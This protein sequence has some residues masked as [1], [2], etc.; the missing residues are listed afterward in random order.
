MF[1]R[2]PSP[3]HADTGACNRNRLLIAVR[4]SNITIHLRL[5]DMGKWAVLSVGK[6]RRVCAYKE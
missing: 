5:C 4:T 6:K 3:L 2:D 1:K